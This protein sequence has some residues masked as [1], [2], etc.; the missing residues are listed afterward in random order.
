MKIVGEKRRKST[1]VLAAREC[2]VG[3]VMILLEASCWFPAGKALGAEEESGGETIQDR[4]VRANDAG[5]AT[6]TA[7]RSLSSQYLHDPSA[8]DEGQSLYRGLCS[9]C[10]GGSAR[11]PR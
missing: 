11:G 5:A 7:G 10:H 2:L 4:S 8:L 1:V 3:F 9:G 6:E